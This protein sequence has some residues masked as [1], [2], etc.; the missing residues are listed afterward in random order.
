[1]KSKVRITVNPSNGQV[2]T[3]NESLGKDGKVYGFIRL[4]QQFVDMTSSVAAVKVR[5]ALKSI[6]QEA[7]EK[8]KNFLTPGMELEGN[9]IVVESLVK[10]P[11]SQVKRA[12]NGENAPVL[13]SNGMPI[14]RRTEYETST[15][16]ADTL[17]KHT[18]T[19]EVQAYVASL[20]AAQTIN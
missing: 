3:A 11:G 1:M 9:I 15:D 2:F 10:E 16:V 4:E 12:G 7:Y 8:A 20:A 19:E 17:I 14:Y 18:N 13:V 5:S 6:S